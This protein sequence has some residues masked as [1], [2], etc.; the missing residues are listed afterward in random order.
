MKVGASKLAAE[1]LRAY[2][3]VVVSIR[4]GHAL[5]NAILVGLLV[6]R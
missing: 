1:V 2:R 3:P 5:A 6:Q 4:D